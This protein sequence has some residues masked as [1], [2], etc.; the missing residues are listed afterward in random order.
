MEQFLYFEVQ[1]KE[2]HFRGLKHTHH[3]FFPTP[4]LSKSEV[5][6]NLKNLKLSCCFHSQICFL[7]NFNSFPIRKAHFHC[8]KTQLSHK[9]QQ[10]QNIVTSH[11][12]WR[13]GNI[14]CC[15]ISKRKINMCILCPRDLESDKLQVMLQKTT[16]GISPCSYPFPQHIGHWV[17]CFRPTL[18]WQVINRVSY[19]SFHSPAHL[20]KG[21]Q[22]YLSCASL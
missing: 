8:P 1:R 16:T 21:S 13:S 4:L 19:F 14:L 22:N 20:F 12:I 18:L 5:E 3:S 9:N 17:E 15:F 11:C 6:W 2:N 10:V 7:S